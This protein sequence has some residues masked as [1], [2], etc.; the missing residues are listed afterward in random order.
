MDCLQ[1]Y[2]DSQRVEKIDL[3]TKLASNQFTEFITNHVK[4]DKILVSVK[5]S[6]DKIADWDNM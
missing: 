4:F 3:A 6:I 5:H 1:I 2:N